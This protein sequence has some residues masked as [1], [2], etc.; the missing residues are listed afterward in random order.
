[1]TELKP[2]IFDKVTD[3]LL[4]RNDRAMEVMRARFAHTKPYRTEPISNDEMLLYYDQMTT[5]VNSQLYLQTLIQRN[6]EDSVRDFIMR[7]EQ[8]KQKRGIENA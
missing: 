3:K 2:S 4:K 1:M 7:M 8:L 5:D 6:G